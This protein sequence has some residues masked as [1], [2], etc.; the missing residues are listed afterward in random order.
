MGK[1]VG[2]LMGGWGEEREVSLKSGAAVAHA[3]EAAGH[4]VTCVLAGPGME[5]ALRTANVE[6]A[7]LAL[8][9]RMG[10]DGKVQGLLEVM[11]LPYTGS[12]V[13][14]SA[15]AMNKT[16]AR[17]LFRLHNL[18]TAAGYSLKA[19]QVDLLEDLHGDLGFPVVVKPASGGSSYGLTLV[20]EPEGLRP[21]VE[22]A[23]RYGGEALVERY[24][25]GREVTVAILEDKVLGTCEVAHGGALF[26]V[27]AK[28]Q[29]QSRYHLPARLSAT[30]LSNVEALAL[31]AYRALGCRGYARVDL[32]ASDE[33]NDVLLEVNTLP[34]MTQSSLLPKIARQAGLSFEALCGKILATASLDDVA[35]RPGADA[36]PATVA[37]AAVRLQDVAAA[38]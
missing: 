27:T 13:L 28:Y 9:G 20:Q 16:Y 24:V 12:G 36:A 30:R 23:C 37:P 26:D 5:V 1:R 2:V 18:P 15:L 35:V 8:H 14:A 22:L 10:E 17:K 11:G 34:G 33:A 38:G 21:A 3:L 32:L 4:D 29:G 31:S 19:S 25:R 7:F 6:V